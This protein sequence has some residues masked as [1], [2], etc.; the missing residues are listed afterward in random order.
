MSFHSSLR[1][2]KIGKDITSQRLADA[3]VFPLYWWISTSFGENLYATCKCHS[4]V[5]ESSIQ[6][7]TQE[8]T[9]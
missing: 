4:F 5:T 9:N 8:G 6:L 3:T 1:R 7:A 2:A